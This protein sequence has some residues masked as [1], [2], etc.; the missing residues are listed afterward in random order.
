MKKHITNN[1]FYQNLF[2]DDSRLKSALVELTNNKIDLGTRIDI[3]MA[4]SVCDNQS[5]IDSLI[6]IAQN[7]FESEALLDACGESLGEIWAKK[8]SL[9]NLD[10][11]GLVQRATTIAE[12]TYKTIVSSE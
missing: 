3:A 7:N 1:E 5:V 2:L 12:A 6:L 4:L 9:P 11:L 8:G 10:T